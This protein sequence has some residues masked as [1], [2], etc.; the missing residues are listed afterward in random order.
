M[1]KKILFCTNEPIWPTS[2]GGSMGNYKTVRKLVERGHDVTVSCPMY[3]DKEI[4]EKNERICVEAFAP[5]Y[6]HKTATFRGP[7]YMA[8]TFLFFF[9]FL[10]LIFRKKY[11]VIYVQNNL[12]APIVFYRLFYHAKYCL[13]MT[14]FLSGFLYDNEHYPNFVV[15]IMMKY[16]RFIPRLFDQIFTISPTMKSTLVSYGVPEGKIVVSYYGADAELFDPGKVKESD[17]RTLKKKLGL[18]EKTVVYHGSVDYHMCGRMIAIIRGVL[19]KTDGI[20][21]ILMGAGKRFDELKKLKSKNVKVLGF[22][23]LDKLPLYLSLAN[24]GMLP[25]ERNV[26]Q[27][28]VLNIKIAEYLAMGLS[29]VSTNLTANREVFGPLG[30][31]SFCDTDKQF[32]DEIIRL[33][34]KPKS[35]KVSSIVRDKFSWDRVTG[36][37]ADSL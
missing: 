15:D 23:D 5:F 12:L 27:D 29:V 24:T 31:I 22:V 9:R 4:V 14:D 13:A 26:N 8:Y 20:S 7:R 21:F 28:N 35:M 30:A 32:V 36:R 11:D 6:V 10:Q 18:K 25:Y 3:S 37:I 19:K 2:T 17:I 1:T 16:E 34:G 33:A